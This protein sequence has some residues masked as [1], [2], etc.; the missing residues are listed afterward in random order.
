MN[1]LKSAGS[2]A[3]TVTD[4]DTH[5]DDTSGSDEPPSTVDT[6]TA[7]SERFSVDGQTAVVTGASSGIG[8]AIAETFA[9]DGADVVICSRE[10]E[11][12]DPVASAI[13][14]GPGGDCL[15]VECDVTE[16][17]A[18]EALV[19]ATVDEFGGLDTLVNNAGAS[20]V[21]SFDDISE[22]GFRTILDINLAGAATCTREAAGHLADGGGTVLNVSSVAGQRGAPY[23]SHYAA[24]KAGLEALTRSLAVEWADRNVRVNCIAPGYVA[25]PGVEQQMGVSADEVDRGTVDR[26]IGESREIADAARFLASDAASFVTG[27]TLVT[28]GVPPAEE[29]P[30]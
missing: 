8:R 17:P 26:R 1:R 2:H 18:V 30:S 4:T 21:S 16:P 15:A 19:E 23:M 12:V 6:P 14:D 11:N 13:T 27:E 24:A 9:A 7:I 10:Q 29:L 28:Q 20:F 22:N 25:T 3:A 5:A